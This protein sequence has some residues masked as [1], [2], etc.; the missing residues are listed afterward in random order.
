MDRQAGRILGI[1]WSG[2]RARRRSYAVGSATK[3]AY[4]MNMQPRRCFPNECGSSRG[5][6][7]PPALICSPPAYLGWL[8]ESTPYIGSMHLPQHWESLHKVCNRRK[9]AL[10]RKIE[11][12]DEQER[13]RPALA[14]L[15]EASKKS[16]E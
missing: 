6:D 13:K 12:L 14:G 3:N 2:E 1:V 15:S 11:L 7:P 16:D 9:H 10:H 4:T 5:A 8:F